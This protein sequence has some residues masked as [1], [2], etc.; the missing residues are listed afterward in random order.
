MSLNDVAHFRF[1]P[2]GV[3]FLVASKML[4]VDSWEVMFKQL[5]MYFLTVMVGLFIHGFIVLQLIYFLVTRKLPFRYIGNFS[6]ALATAFATSSR[7]IIDLNF[8][9]ITQLI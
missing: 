2:I 3:L 8:I 5:G 9:R 7:S 1:A 4:E 6:E